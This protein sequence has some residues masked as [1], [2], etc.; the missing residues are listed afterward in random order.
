MSAKVSQLL[1]IAILALRGE[2]RD[3]PSPAARAATSPLRRFAPRGR[4]WT[5]KAVQIAMVALLGGA[6]AHA[7]YQPIPNFTG[8]GAGQQF[9]NAVNGL[10]SGATPISP[11]LVALP[12]SAL[13][14]TPEQDGQVFWCRDC[15]QGAVCSTGGSN[16]A[17]AVGANGQWTCNLG[18]AEL[19][20]GPSG[21]AGG[22]L[23]SSYPNPIVNTVRDGQTPVTTQN[24][25]NT[26]GQATG[27]YSMNGNLLRGLQ[28]GAAT[29]DALSKNQSVLTDLAGPGG[30]NFGMAG[31]TFNSVGAAAVG[32]EPVVA[33]VVNTA[34]GTYLGINNRLN[35][36]TYAG[37]KGDAIVCAA[38][39]SI[40]GST[41][42]FG[43]GCGSF[44]GFS[45]ADT[46]KYLAVSAAGPGGAAYQGTLTYISSSSATLSPAPTANV[47]NKPFAYGTDD[48]TAFQTTETACENAGYTAMVDIPPGK[49]I[50]G[51]VQL[52][53]PST[54]AV[55][56]QSTGAPGCV[57][58]TGAG[59]FGTYILAKPGAAYAFQRHNTAGVTVEG[60]TF[61]GLLFDGLILDQPVGLLDMSWLAGAPAPTN[62]FRD[63]QF[64]YFDG[65]GFN[66]DLDNDSNIG[67]MWSASFW[68]VGQSQTGTIST[69]TE[70]TT[71]AC[72]SG[73]TATCNI[74]S[75]P[76]V[77]GEW[78][79]ISG[80]SVSSP[81]GGYDFKSAVPIVAATSSS[82]S[83]CTYATSLG[84]G[85]SGTATLVPIS[86]DLR[87]AGGQMW[88]HDIDSGAGGLLVVGAQNWR[89]ANFGIYGGIQIFP[90]NDNIGEID[91]TQFLNGDPFDSSIHI[92]A[93]LGGTNDGTA[94]SLLL[95]DV[96]AATNGSSSTLF[97][98][99]WWSGVRWEGGGI[100][101][102]TGA[103]TVF[104]SIN[105]GGG[106]WFPRFD[107]NGVALRGATFN[108]PND[109]EWTLNGSCEAT[110]GGT[111]TTLTGSSIIGSSLTCNGAKQ[112][113]ME[114][115][116]SAAG[117]IVPGGGSNVCAS[118][119]NSREPICALDTSTAGCTTGATYVSGGSY[120]CRLFCSGTT[121]KNTGAPC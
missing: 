96:W 15:A 18:P 37:A 8:V 88:A 56:G 114:T 81:N 93:P 45:S 72:L 9:R 12:F 70:S 1:T 26:L 60:M 92:E 42:T 5:R 4:A 108:P 104:G 55:P 106:N 95:R 79:T 74:A 103:I 65:V 107:F 40:S 31:L 102:D 73:Q 110:S 99:R 113:N 57:V 105:A 14:V 69:C 22:D 101:A 43:S 52:G 62:N 2:S 16:G 48:T 36:I 53:N 71:S 77:A 34:S 82:I 120:Q 112:I 59:R 80:N 47:S 117:T 91:G 10:G 7:Q 64:R 11:R 46:G 33:G 100:L 13:N 17:V 66:A 63:M 116:F 38:G 61:G 109:I 49:Y 75:N 111:N 50:T 39:G 35:P 86:M 119:L 94:K 68:N 58:T 6:P 84:T 115:A 20:G 98:G 89:L 41:F 25:I 24:G 118:I 67:E 90:S 78:A 51:P 30:T 54:A 27:N 3:L 29:G 85:T 32:G 76:F 44:P 121:W 87:G 23:G 83:Y 19:G 28:L 97:D 21:V